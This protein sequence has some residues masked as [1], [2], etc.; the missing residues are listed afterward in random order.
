MNSKFLWLFSFLMMQQ[1]RIR[2]LHAQG[3]KAAFLMQQHDHF[4]L[5]KHKDSSNLCSL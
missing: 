2:I 5:L 1:V 3:P 4:I